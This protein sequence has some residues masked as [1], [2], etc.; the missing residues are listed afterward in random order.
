MLA[1]AGSILLAVLSGVLTWQHWSDAT[2]F[3]QQGTPVSFGIIV[4]FEIATAGIGAVVLRRIR[5]SELSAAWVALVVGIHF[6]PLAWLLQYSLLYPV[7]AGVV[8][9][10]VAAVPVARSRFLMPSAVAGVGTGSVLFAAALFS[11][12]KVLR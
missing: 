12:T 6:V 5:R 10:A 1:A 7:A 3:E 9:V 4:G 2:V 8:A 11:V